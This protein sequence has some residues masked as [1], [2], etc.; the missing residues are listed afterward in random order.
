MRAMV[1]DGNEDRRS[2]T[3]GSNNIRGWQKKGMLGVVT[4]G[5]FG[6]IMM[7]YRRESSGLLQTNRLEDLV[8]GR[9]S[10]SRSLIDLSTLATLSSGQGDIV[11]ADG[12]GVHGHPRD[13]VGSSEAGAVALDMIAWTR[14]GDEPALGHRRHR[15]WFDSAAAPLLF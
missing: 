1:I 4:S 14:R 11:M 2:R 15:R 9:T 12:D 3:I 6:G 10:L 7:D 8:P 5:G 13:G